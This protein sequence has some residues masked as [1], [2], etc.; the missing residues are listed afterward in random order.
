M[1]RGLSDGQVDA[2]GRIIVPANWRTLVA[3]EANG[4]LVVTIDPEE[5]CLLMYPFP[6]WLEIEEKLESLPTFQPAARRI[7]RLLI[8][9]A[10]E[11]ELDKQGR[12]LLPGLL[13]EYAQLDKAVMLVGQGKKI[14]IWNQ[15]TWEDARTIWLSKDPEINQGSAMEFS[16]LSL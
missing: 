11:V 10:S 8:G 5:P 6:R 13:R 2:K 4:A 16:G 7:Q 12:I 15:N 14:E 1:F 3:E 9:H